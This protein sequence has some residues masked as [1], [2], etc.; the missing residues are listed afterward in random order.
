MLVKS[1]KIVG[2]WGE[3]LESRI[4]PSRKSGFA[5]FPSLPNLKHL[6]EGEDKPPCWSI[7]LAFSTKGPGSG[8]LAFKTA[9]G[10]ESTGG[11]AGEEGVVGRL[12]FW[13]KDSNGSAAAELGARTFL[14]LTGVALVSE[15]VE[16]FT[17]AW[18][19]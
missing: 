6:T 10:E 11:S 8:E 19:F 5:E 9:Q 17:E 18:I 14:L 13:K 1:K 16:L 4:S 15:R 12:R 2:S 7:S 3:L